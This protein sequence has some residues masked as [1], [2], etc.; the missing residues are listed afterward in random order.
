MILANHSP[1]L[2]YDDM[3]TRDNETAPTC[4]LYVCGFPCQPFSISGKK[5]CL[6]DGRGQVGFY[7]LDYIRTKKPTHFVLENVKHFT[8]CQDGKVFE[9]FMNELRSIQ[10]YHVH[11][12]ILNT[13]DYGIPQSR[14]RL[15][16]VGT[17]KKDF[18][19]PDPVPRLSLSC[20]I[21]HDDTSETN[22]SHT[23]CDRAS[24]C[25]ELSR[26]MM[27]R[28]LPVVFFDQLHMQRSKVDCINKGGYPVCPCITANSYHWNVPMGR[29]ANIKELLMLQ[30]LPP[31]IDCSPVP[32][33]AMRRL[34]GN[35]MSA[36]VLEHI[37][38]SLFLP[39]TPHQM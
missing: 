1:R 29:K 32:E 4:D 22:T 17:Q 2:F 11:C 12:K 5:L 27:D 21:D 24:I 39:R 6:E 20:F 13:S 19:F 36:N 9:L 31:D 38:R 10:G 15:Y 26:Q 37:F 7:C 30:G 3:T 16:I 28:N 8:S 33:T 14:N 25:R 35:A 18:V 34:I 23:R